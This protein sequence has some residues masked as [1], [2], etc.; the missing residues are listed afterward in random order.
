MKSEE[1][2]RDE[3]RVKNEERRQDREREKGKE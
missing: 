1:V 2:K 3:R